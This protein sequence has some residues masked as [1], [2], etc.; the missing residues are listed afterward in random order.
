MTENKGHK[1]GGDDDNGEDDVKTLH[2]FPY[3]RKYLARQNKGLYE[4]DNAST[5]RSSI[6]RRPSV[7]LPYCTLTTKL[8]EVGEE[9][10]MVQIRFIQQLYHHQHM[11]AHYFTWEK[12]WRHGRHPR[13]PCT[14]PL[15]CAT[16]QA[17]MLIHGRT[18]SEGGTKAAPVPPSPHCPG[19]EGRSRTMLPIVTAS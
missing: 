4:E 19:V 15:P 11:L 17:Q 1:G 5:T 3:M 13:P 2:I 10:A 14:A 6:R 7:H 8:R 12:P 16:P 18:A 9:N